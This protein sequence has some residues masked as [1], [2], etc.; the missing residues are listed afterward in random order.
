MSTSMEFPISPQTI[1]EFKLFKEELH[2]LL[3]NVLDQAETLQT[4]A[5]EPVVLDR[6]WIIG[7]LKDQITAEKYVLKP[8]AVQVTEGLGNL[9]KIPRELR[10]LIYGYAIVGGQTAIVR[11]SKQTH[12]EA[13]EL[14]FQNGIYRLVIGFGDDIINPPLSQ[15]LAKNIKNLILRV[16][17]RGF[18]IDG[19]DEDLPILHMFD[20]SNIQR[21]DCVVTVVCDPFCG[22]M[23]AF[24]VVRALDNLTGF[25]RVI[26][27]LDLEWWGEPWPDTIDETQEYRIWARI[28]GAVHHQKKL[29]E[30]TLGTGSYSFD[31]KGLRLAFHPRK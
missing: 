2:A 28:N 16:N 5:E 3:D 20:G 18:F 31:E 19:V 26:L 9:L 11:A 29:L 17:G 7:T 25:E 4:T 23:D 24:Q 13:S 14:I 12:K 8:G 22:E 27:E 1:L 30:P 21:K 10:D 6:D 15:S